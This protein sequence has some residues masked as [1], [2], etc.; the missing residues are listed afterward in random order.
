MKLSTAAILLSTMLLSAC[1]PEQIAIKCPSL[2]NPPKT[3]VV[4]LEKA[5]QGDVKA[6]AYVIALEKHYQKLGVCK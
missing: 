5:A 6:R 4:A 1:T 2:R 3:V